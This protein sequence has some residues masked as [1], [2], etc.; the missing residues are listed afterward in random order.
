MKFIVFIGQTSCNS[1][2]QRVCI[3]SSLVRS[4]PGPLPLCS[5][6]VKRKILSEKCKIITVICDSRKIYLMLIVGLNGIWQCSSSLI[7]LF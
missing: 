7:L 2:D 3:K 5:C 4:W 1:D 6:H